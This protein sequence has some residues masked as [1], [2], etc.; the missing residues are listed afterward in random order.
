MLLL[1]FAS[2][3]AVFSQGLGD[4][5]FLETFGTINDGSPQHI[6]DDKRT[7]TSSGVYF[8]YSPL[9]YI[10]S[11]DFYSP[12]RWTESGTN[13]YKTNR[14]GV[15]PSIAPGVS[16]QGT[17]PA[18]VNQGNWGPVFYNGS[19][20]TNS[21]NGVGGYSLVNDSR[22]YF[23]S[24]LEAAPDHT[25]GDYTGYMLVV[26]AH[27]STKLYFDRV[28]DGLC[29][30]T[31]FRFSVWIKDL[32]NQN[33][34]KPKVKFKIYNANT[35]VSSTSNTGLIDS[36]S[37]VNNDVSPARTW[38]QLYFDF[39]MPAG[40]SSVRLQIENIVNTQYG[41]DLAIDDIS[42][43]P[44][45]P[46]V[47]LSG[48]AAVCPG[49]DPG[50]YA[51]IIETNPSFRYPGPLTFMQLQ[52]RLPGTAAWANIGSVKSIAS[53]S[54]ANVTFPNPYVD[55]NVTLDDTK[56][57]E[58][59]VLVAGDQTTLNNPLCRSVSQKLVSI[60]EH[61][62]KLTASPNEVCE[63]GSATLFA[64][65]T[66]TAQGA[67][68]VYSWEKKV[69][70][71]ASAWEAATDS[72]NDQ[73]RLQITN[74]QAT[75]EYRVT[76]AV[77]GEN[78]DFANVSTTISV[79]LSADAGIDGNL[80][81][82][83]S[84][85][86]TNKQLFEALGGTPDEGG[87]W[88]SVGNI[89]TYTVEGGDLCPDATSTVTVTIQE[90]PDAGGNGTLTICEG[91]TPTNAQLFASLTGTPDAGGTWT[92]E[93]L[94]Y[95][96]TV[97]ATAPCTEAATATVTVTIQEGPDAGGNGTLTICEGTTPTN[98]QLFA[99]LTGTPD[100]GGTW[101]N[102]GLVYTYTV[103]ATA[104]CTEAATATVT[105]TIQEGPDAGGNG[106]L[107]VCEGT[108]PTN[109]QLFAS[110]T[111]IPDAGGT[112]TNEGLVYTYT[113]AATAPC[114]EAATATVTVTIQEGPD[115][116]GNG[117]LTICEG[118]T[119][120]NA[121]LFASLTGT[122]D[123]GGTW[124]NVG[125]VYTYT[126]AATTPCTEAA[127]STVTVTENNTPN[128]GGNGTLTICEGTTPT[129]AQLF[130]SL[131]GTPDAGGTWTNEGLVYTYTVA[132]TAPCTEA[133]TATVTVTIQE[134][135]DAGGNGTLT[136]CEGTTP[137][138]AQLFASLTGTPDAGGT[139]TNE[140]LVYTYT[141]AATAPC[142][143][144]A[145]ATVTVTIQEGPDAG[146][147]GTL[148]VCE[149]T[150]PTNAQLFASLTGSP[151]A[152]GTWT[153]E[154][155]VYTYTVA[156]TAP[157]TEAA[158]ATVT[159]TIQEGPDAGGNGTLTICEG[160]TPTNAQLFASLTGT[161]DAGGTWTNEGLVYTYTVAATAPCTEAATAT[162]TV[163]IQEGPDAG[164]NGT[165]T[166]CEGTI[167]TNAQ[168]FAS[169]TGTPDAG[170]TWTNEGLVY[171]YTVAATAPCTEAATSTVTVI[172]ESV[173]LPVVG[174]NQEVCFSET[175]TSLTAMAEVSEGQ[176]LVWYNSEF[177]G[178][179]V[180]DPSLNTIGTVTYWAEA[181]S[182]LGCK[183][184]RVPVKLTINDCDIALVKSVAPTNTGDDCIEA[185][186]ELTYTFVVTNQGN[187][188]L[189]NVAIDEESFSGTGTLGTITF[190]SSSMNS[191]AGTLKPGESATYTATYTVTPADVEAGL[192]TNQAEAEGFFGQTRVFDL[193]GSTVDNNTETEYELCQ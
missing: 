187:V 158:T 184:S 173:D 149:G 141:V 36:K 84:S 45:G 153:N 117:T 19:N 79:S 17:R 5:V 22:G 55:A 165:L 97:A 64:D 99:S 46:E 154:G 24:Y 53:T 166:I 188:T 33:G 7:G 47:L 4:P 35:Y 98:A 61:K 103:A 120:T 176:T 159:V 49:S 10:N 182:P 102:E 110:L 161:P 137:T 142:T 3:Q 156:A 9:P 119:P 145:T 170:G 115:A 171:T 94:V 168:L 72:D 34:E 189:M 40:V 67:T 178:I 136:V 130:A 57:Y 38:K 11:I 65:L 152:G 27:S 162:V 180:N 125:N 2:E 32:N 126:V 109:A 62:V 48:D 51:N 192:I 118:T 193:S 37:T 77:N 157:C 160:T 43:S 82:C 16:F 128:A 73:T 116:G 83:E 81:I 15:G 181:V 20:V 163:T 155:L 31:K 92:N 68:Y 23:Q 151:D 14:N 129:N 164:G 59:R 86:P 113:V 50:L 26:D 75:T 69:N 93:G 123:A 80:T 71:S 190:Q 169:L 133:A 78:C 177:D 112:W 1:F 138:N 96:Y 74:L 60:Y 91:T 29:A 124:T 146:G 148:T 30:G 8:K 175:M 143:E 18:I 42:F 13:P 179:V 174:D 89:Y 87:I 111:G 114:T 63:G 183:S 150:T 131:T 76:V 106:T 127:T 132:A 140:G 56:S 44:I 167:P 28:I 100:A 104:P 172:L 101:T 147:N 105:V 25:S 85:T 185:G 186:D 41:N 144:A 134:G 58:F 108:T 139:W 88:T 107:T 121:Q 90:G 66:N 21:Q 39:T 191:A 12:Q 52:Y 122:P 70:G 135:P 54:S 6:F 95:T